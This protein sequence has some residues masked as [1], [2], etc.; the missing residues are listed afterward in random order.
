MTTGFDLNQLVR[1]QLE[2]G[3]LSDVPQQELDQLAAG[4]REQLEYSVGAR[5]M[6]Q[7]TEEQ[8]EEF[9]Q[10]D[11][12]GDEGS[13]FLNRYIPDHQVV[14]AACLKELLAELE[15]AVRGAQAGVSR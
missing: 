4:M 15:Q 9:D 7:L 2:A 13:E 5:L 10:L 11:I 12:D 6:E 14:V 8:I 3:G 1:E